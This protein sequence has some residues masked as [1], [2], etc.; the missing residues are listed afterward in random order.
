[1]SGTLVDST[2]KYLQILIIEDS[3]DD[4]ILLVNELK[5]AGFDVTFKRVETEA[6]T[7]SALDDYEWDIVI[8]DYILPTFSGLETLELLKRKG[9]D[10]P[11][12]IVS[13]KISDETAVNAMRAGAKDYITKDNLSRLG[14]A[15]EREL[16]EAV[17]RKEH[18]KAEEQLKETNE[19]KALLLEH[20]PLAMLAI[21]PDS[22]IRYANKA[23]EKLTGFSSGELIGNSAPYIFWPKEKIPEYLK[24]IKDDEFINIKTTQKLFCKKNNEEFWVDMT[25][26]PIRVNGKLEY[27]LSTWVNL[28]E[29]KRLRKELELFNHRIIQAQEEERKRIARELHEDTVQL[30]AII[31]LEIESLARSAGT[32][33]EIRKKLQYLKENTDHAMQDIRRFSYALRP[34]E[35]DYLGLDTTLEQLAEDINEQ[36]ELTVLFE[37][38]GKSRR[39]S[40]DVELVL[41]RIAQEAI[42]NIQKHARATMAQIIIEYYPEKVRLA[43]RDNGKG[44]SMT[45]ESESAISNGRL[46]LIGMRERSH[47]INADLRI[48]SIPNQGT[49]ILV[50]VNRPTGARQ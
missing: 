25:T 2:R 46:G 18:R 32:S 6:T 26:I 42:N 40:G 44:F 27:I 12:I 20:S 19:F 24:E 36:G 48:E 43:V 38:R 33:E 5:K 28:T 21:N 23:A 49:T 30:L 41:F 29:E 35:L 17:I 8:S 7:S 22:S 14:P 15:V 3:E 13:G 31:K 50:E 45:K 9:L 4:T 37:T 47:L 11:C 1:M 39:L 34:G 10:T 16:N